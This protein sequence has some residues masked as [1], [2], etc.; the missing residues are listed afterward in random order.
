MN[1]S[2]IQDLQG[3]NNIFK[4]KKTILFMEEC[5]NLILEQLGI[6]I[7]MLIIIVTWTIIWKMLALWKAAR[8]NSPVWFVILILCNTVGILEILYIFFF[9]KIKTNNFRRK[10]ARK[11]KR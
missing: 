5:M 6:S 8:N 7:W 4:Q 1:N 9:S 11:K 2:N 3:G 10:K